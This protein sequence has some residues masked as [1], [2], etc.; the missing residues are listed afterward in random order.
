MIFYF[1]ETL[2]FHLIAKREIVFT[3]GGFFDLGNTLIWSVSITL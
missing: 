1:Q 2:Q 3:A